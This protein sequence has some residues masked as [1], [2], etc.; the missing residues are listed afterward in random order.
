MSSIWEQYRL[1]KMASVLPKI[2]RTTVL[3]ANIRA[4][5]YLATIGV[6]SDVAPLRGNVKPSPI[7]RLKTC[8]CPAKTTGS[9]WYYYDKPAPLVCIRRYA[10]EADDEIRN[11]DCN[12][13]E[14]KRKLD[15]NAVY[16]VD[17]RMPDELVEDGRIPGS[18]NIPRKFELS[19]A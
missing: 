15:S 19:Q 5:S 9:S 8:S 13:D 2:L 3:I 11:P 4:S 16:L 14:L 6:H 7:S 17:V 10:S 12:V 18:V 1:A